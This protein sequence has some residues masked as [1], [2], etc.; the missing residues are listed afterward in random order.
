MMVEWLEFLYLG[1]GRYDSQTK[2]HFFWLGFLHLFH[3][4]VKTEP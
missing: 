4:N 2:G 3:E 1:G